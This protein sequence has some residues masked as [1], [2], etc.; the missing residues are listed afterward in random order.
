MNY[1][2]GDVLEQEDSR[3]QIPSQGSDHKG[4]SVHLRE[5]GAG[6]KQGHEAA[7]LSNQAFQESRS[8]S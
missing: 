5:Q 8:G 6:F 3:I 1:F 7:S 4:H 2:K